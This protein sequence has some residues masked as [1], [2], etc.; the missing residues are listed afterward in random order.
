MGVG[1]H[2][3][4][5]RIHEEYG[6]ACILVLH[7]V[8]ILEREQA[9]SAR[10]LRQKTG[11]LLDPYTCILGDPRDSLGYLSTVTLKGYEPSVICVVAIEGR[12]TRPGLTLRYPARS[13]SCGFTEFQAQL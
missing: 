4:H 10:D 1:I 11:H 7:L 8:H 2:Y 6:F 12:D 13:P 9:P 3:K 5:V